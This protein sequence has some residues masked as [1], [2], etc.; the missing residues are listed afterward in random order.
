[1][2]IVQTPLRISLA[3]GGTDFE[4]F[5]SNHGGAVLS[6]AINKYVFAIV[7][8]RFD[9]TIVLSYSKRERVKNV[10]QIKHEL[11]REAMK[12]TGVEKGIELTTLADIPSAGTGLGSSSSA[13]VALLH[14]LYSYQNKLKNAQE[15]AE[16]ACKIEIDILK[17]P[18]G[19]QDQYIAA[20]GG[21]QFIE[22]NDCVKVEDIKLSEVDKQKLSGNLLLFYTGITR[23]SNAVLKEQNTNIN[24]NSLILRKIR[25][26]AFQGKENIENGDFDKLGDLLHYSWELKKQLANGITNG[27]ID[28]IYQKALDSGATGGKVTGAG[29]GG[30]LL[31]YVPKEKQD[32]VRNALRHLR[33]LPFRFGSDG[34]KIIFNYRRS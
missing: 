26:L 4:G 18:I 2:I 29:G 34:T 28:K 3:G 11:I 9:D 14:V 21:L 10:S 7:E 31:L 6:T 19:K 32:S 13:T 8:K 23:S 22:F 27:V 24:S 15:L 12:T 17:S 16:E 20:F 33:E 5:Y 25:E 30:F 1:V